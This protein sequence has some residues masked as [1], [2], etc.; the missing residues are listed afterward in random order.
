MIL[1]IVFHRW[2]ARKKPQE[3]QLKPSHLSKISPSPLRIKNDRAIACAAFV[4]QDQVL[5]GDC[6]WKIADMRIYHNFWEGFKSTAM[7]L[8]HLFLI[9]KSCRYPLHIKTSYNFKVLSSILKYQLL[10]LHS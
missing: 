9:P 4:N 7:E 3:A 1:Y 10:K 8:S 6:N 2:L 5:G